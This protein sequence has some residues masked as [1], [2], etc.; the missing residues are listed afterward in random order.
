[1]GRWRWLNWALLAVAAVY[2]AWFVLDRSEGSFAGS[3]PQEWRKADTL[4][5][6]SS[7]IELLLH[8]DRERL[9][10]RVPR[11]PWLRLKSA[12]LQRPTET[13]FE[14]GRNSFELTLPGGT[15]PAGLLLIRLESWTGEEQ[16][17]A[18]RLPD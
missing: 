5:A 8:R 6:A 7:G 17:L 12:C 18:F 15:F 13:C 1:M 3:P 9:R 16:S 10:L 14:G 11:D 4:Q 2:G